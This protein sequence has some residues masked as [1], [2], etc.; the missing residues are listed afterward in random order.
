M[1]PWQIRGAEGKGALEPAPSGQSLLVPNAA[2]DETD[3]FATPAGDMERIIH[4]ATIWVAAGMIAPGV[5][6]GPL[7][8]QGWRPS[9]LPP[10]A[11][12]PFWIGTALA[13]FGVGLLVWAGCPVIRAEQVVASLRKSA[14]VRLRI[15]FE[16]AGIAIALLALLLSPR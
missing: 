11:A 3:R 8:A 7:L 4:S 10:V 9:V 14:A 2:Q 15:P 12:I 16:V 6:L 13:A 5:V 1:P